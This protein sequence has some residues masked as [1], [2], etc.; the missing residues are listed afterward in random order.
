MNWAELLESLDLVWDF[1]LRVVAMTTDNRNDADEVVVGQAKAAWSWDGTGAILVGV[2]GA[3]VYTPN[4]AS[5]IALPDGWLEVNG[6]PPFGEGDAFNT[7]VEP[8]G[9][10]WNLN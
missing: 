8:E 3:A 7:L 10:I 9:D 6:E 2:G 4:A 1:D 5:V